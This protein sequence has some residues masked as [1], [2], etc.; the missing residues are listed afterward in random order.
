M[1]SNSKFLSNEICWALDIKH[2]QYIKLSVQAK[3]SIPV[4]Y[5]MFTK[6]CLNTKMN[7]GLKTTLLPT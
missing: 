5:L 4:T 1:L 3:L 7:D 2:L 6:K